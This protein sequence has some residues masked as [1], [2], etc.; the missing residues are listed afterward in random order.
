MAV[1]STLSASATEE[2]RASMPKD[3]F[4][5]IAS[6]YVPSNIKTA[7]RRALLFY[8]SDILIMRMVNKLAEYP[9]TEVEIEMKD[10]SGDELDLTEEEY[11]ANYRR[12]F[13]RSLRIHESLISIGQDYFLYQNV[14]PYISLP[15]DR[16]Y[17]CEKCSSDDNKEEHVYHS[18]AQISKLTW[19]GKDFK[20]ECPVCKTERTL[21]SKEEEVRNGYDRVRFKKRNLYR[22]GIE[23]AEITGAVRYTYSMNPATRKKIMSNDRF[24]LDNTPL[25]FLKSA[26]ANKAVELEESHVYHF[27]APTP[28]TPDGS[29]WA[30]PLIV[31]AVQTI[32][33]IQNM[34]KAM[35]SISLE[36]IDPKVFIA[37]RMNPDALAMK[38]D[39]EKITTQIK[40]GYEASRGGATGPC[41]FPLPVEVGLMNLNGRMFLPSNEIKEGMSDLFIGMGMP[42]GLL[43]GEGPYQANSIAIRVIENGFITYRMYLNN[44]LQSIA[45]ELSGF[46]NMPPIKVKL[47]ELI[48]L[49]DSLHKQAL[50]MGVGSKWISKDTYLSA[51]GLDPKD[52]EKKVTEE[53]LKEAD[54]QG[55]AENRIEIARAKSMEDAEIDRMANQTEMFI[56]ESNK[57]TEHLVSLVDGLVSKG[58][59]MEW[60]TNYVSQYMAA[61]AAKAEQQATMQ[62]QQEA[63]DA[64]FRDRMAGATHSLN[65]AEDKRQMTLAMQ[66]PGGQNQQNAGQ[67]GAGINNLVGK[68][69]SMD[70]T[71]RTRELGYMKTAQPTVW[72]QVVNVL[73]TMGMYNANG[74]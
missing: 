3:P 16:V 51:L 37:P 42:R 60:A 18:S 61:E 25:I 40:A 31:A 69:M 34:K 30:W 58:Y 23:Q 19:D 62:R 47:K 14:F 73:G 33:Y 53:V 67:E 12:I 54:R 7:F 10:P 2:A 41:V 52:E 5:L 43:S 71:T 29:P 1:T 13:D 20:G 35:E 46:F 68:L 45:D 57:R 56:N 63:R 36:H 22:I 8:K 49:D 6:Q 50:A 15:I 39:M 32:F 27:K 72:A 28:T 59:T 26:H 44:C 17:K 65:R 55:E 11:I 38:Y 70:D 4:K 21:I 74:G 64:F 9:I 66:P 24:T 48:K